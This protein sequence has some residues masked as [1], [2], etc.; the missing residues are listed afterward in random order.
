MVQ[1]ETEILK[2]NPDIYY[3]RIF[4]VKLFD[5]VRLKAFFCIIDCGVSLVS[6][7]S[8]KKMMVEDG[9]K[10]RPVSDACRFL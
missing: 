7:I 3:V 1:K 2:C 9:S 5:R 6:K 10:S 8:Q 4:G